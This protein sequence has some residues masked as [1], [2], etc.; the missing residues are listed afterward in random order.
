MKHRVEAARNVQANRFEQSQLFSNS[1][2]DSRH[3]EK[4]CTL[5]STCQ[6]VLKKAVDILGFSA[7]ACHSVIRV[8]RTIADL[9]GE[10]MIKKD[11]LAEAIQYRSYDRTYLM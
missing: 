5:D 10:Q 6:E 7:R 1:G 11:H 8:A 9:N 2:M 3:I 4:F